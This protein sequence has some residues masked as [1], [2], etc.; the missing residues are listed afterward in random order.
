[1]ETNPNW[2]PSHIGAQRQTD[3]IKWILQMDDALI[4]RISEAI[5][6]PAGKVKE[7]AEHVL[8]DDGDRYD[9]WAWYAENPD[10]E[11]KI[12]IDDDLESLTGTAGIDGGDLVKIYANGWRDD[13]AEYINKTSSERLESLEAV[14]RY[15]ARDP[16][17]L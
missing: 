2:I 1:M 3:E 11:A 14:N 12:V 7:V 16:E 13:G 5:G 17:A 15:L 9:D 4:M 6:I 10:T 8:L